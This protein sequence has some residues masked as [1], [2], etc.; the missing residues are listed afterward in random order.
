MMKQILKYIILFS[1]GG[2]LYC[3]IEMLW[4]GRTHWTMFFV[5]GLCFILCG[6]INEILDWQMPLW[7]QMLICATGITLI[8]FISGVIINIVLKLNVWDY[9]HLPLNICGQVCLLYSFFWF[10][11]SCA[12]IVLD[13]WLR[14]WLFKEEKPHSIIF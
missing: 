1:I 10:I 12:A 6:S 7:K 3:G 8:E 11:L 5:G 14:Y 4:R 2:L 13:D 9:S